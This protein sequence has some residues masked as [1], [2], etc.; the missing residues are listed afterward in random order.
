[1]RSNPLLATLTALALTGCG[2]SVAPMM[3][4]TSDGAVDATATKTVTFV[5]T[6]RRTMRPTPLATVLVRAETAEGDAIESVTDSNG[7]VSLSLATQRR[8]DIT[9]AHR[10][11][12]VRSIM[13]LRPEATRGEIALWMPPFFDKASAGSMA[14][15]TPRRFA[16]PTRH[17]Q[18]SAAN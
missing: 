8:W 4:A 10:D 15:G 5:V 13:G 6:T 3:D 11:T 2:V 14:R 9:F 1:M 17:A 16:H 12:G 18:L 7:R